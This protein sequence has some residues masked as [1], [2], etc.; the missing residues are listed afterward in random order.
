MHFLKKSLI[1]CIKF[2]LIL[3]FLNKSHAN[4]EYDDILC[5]FKKPKLE[6]NFN[7]PMI[8]PKIMQFKFEKFIYAASRYRSS[9][10]TGDYW[11]IVGRM[12]SFNVKKNGNIISWNNGSNYNFSL[13]KNGELNGWNP[14]IE[15]GAISKAKNCSIL[16]GPKSYNREIIDKKLVWK[17][18]NKK[19]FLKNEQD[20]MVPKVVNNDSNVS[21]ENKSL[22]KNIENQGNN[23]SDSDMCSKL[24][25]KVL[26]HID[27]DEY[28][29]ASAARKLMKEMN[30][31]SSSNRTSNNQSYTAPKNI[32]K[33]SSSEL[34]CSVGPLGKFM[35]REFGRYNVKAFDDNPPKACNQTYEYCKARARAIAKGAR[36]PSSERSPNS[37]SADCNITGTNR[38][39]TTADCTVTP[40]RGGG[41]FAGG[42]ANELGKGIE[43]TAAMKRVYV[44]SFERCMTE[45]GYSVSER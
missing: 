42:L 24:Q 2:T 39:N 26:A 45:M 5:V 18:L 15:K 43:R 31:S 32:S 6:Q 36:I 4:S 23:Y 3:S 14:T 1:F 8:I 16:V 33:Y 19:Y 34:S 9:K 20:S 22:N 12:N 21:S 27:N 7:V 41:G 37:Y 28:Q 11:F 30:C 25:N 13:D 44:S 38:F 17:H 35:F 29:K 10:V 40:D